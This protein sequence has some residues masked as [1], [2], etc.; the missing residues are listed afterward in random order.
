MENKP[1]VRPWLLVTTIATVAGGLYLSYVELNRPVATSHVAMHTEMTLPETTVDTDTTSADGTATTAQVSVKSSSLAGYLKKEFGENI[2]NP[3]M[4]LRMLGRLV[5][6]LK[7]Q[8]G[9]GW[10]AKL[11][12][13][14]ALSF[15]ELVEELMARYEASKVFSEWHLATAQAPYRDAS[16]RRRAEWDKRLE[17]FGDDAKKIWEDDYQQYRMETALVDIDSSSEGLDTRVSQYVDAMK[18]VYGNNFAERLDPV[19]RQAGFLELGSTQRDLA[20]MSDRD[21]A[22]AL[23]AIRESIGIDKPAIERLAQLDADRDAERA[24]GEAYMQARQALQGQY[25]GDELQ[26]RVQALREETFLPDEVET[27]R[28]EEDAGYFRFSQPRIFGGN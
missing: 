3:Y 18:S 1:Q 5:E 24:R 6:M 8:Y 19:S 21:R 9:D 2:A 26:T 17:V 7:E 16:E 14:L 22:A 11:R 4:Q 13:I 12:E 25:T 28:G 20:G 15:P 10:E 23:R 27:I